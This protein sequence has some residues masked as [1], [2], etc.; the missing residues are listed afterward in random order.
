MWSAEWSSLATWSLNQT[1]YRKKEKRL[2]SLTYEQRVV[3]YYL[4][5]PCKTR[6]LCQRWTSDAMFTNPWYGGTAGP[7]A[8]AVENNG[9]G[10]SAAS[11]PALSSKSGGHLGP[12]SSNSKDG[13]NSPSSTMTNNGLL[14]NLCEMPSVKEHLAV[15]QAKLKP[16]WTVHVSK[17][18]RLYYCKWVYICMCFLFLLS[19]AST[20]L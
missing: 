10:S 12:S 3:R 20:V 13:K 5:T 17:D 19:L 8:A 14:S 1:H 7:P 18:G 15:V 11:S 4:T 9:H 16:G 6:W 2:C